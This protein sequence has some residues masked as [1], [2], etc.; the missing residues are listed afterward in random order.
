MLRGQAGS[1]AAGLVCLAVLYD[2]RQVI[3]GLGQ[4]TGATEP[5]VDSA[6]ACH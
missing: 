2:V 6:G 4:P 3:G 5:G 1:G